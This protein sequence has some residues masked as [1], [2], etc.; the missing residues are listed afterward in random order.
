LPRTTD[1]YTTG[2]TFIAGRFL[3]CKGTWQGSCGFSDSVLEVFIDGNQPPGTQFTG[4]ALLYNCSR[5]CY[6][7]HLKFVMVM[8]EKRPQLKVS[9][10]SA[11]WSHRAWPYFAIFIFAL[12]I[13]LIYLSEIIDHPI[14]SILLGDAESYDVWA[15]E[16]VQKG[17]IGERTFYQ[18]PFYPY[19]LAFIYTIGAR[20]FIIVRLVQIVIGSASCVLLAAAGARFFGK[21]SGWIAG[22]LLSLYAPALFFD[23][24]IQ[25]AVLAM[26]FMC[27]LLFLMSRTTCLQNHKVRSGVWILIGATLACF[28]LVRENALILV[29]ATVIWLII[30]FWKSGWRQLLVKGMFLAVGL[31]IVFFPVTLRNYVVGG[32]FV[33]TTSQLGPNFYIGNSKEATGFYRPLIW[34]HS[35]WKFERIDAQNLAEKELGRVLTPNEVSD[36]WLAAAL[37][38]MREDPANW[39]RLMGR[40]W[41]MVWNS[42]EISDS[43]SIYA[44]YRFSNL[45]NAL[46]Q[47]FHFGVL[48]PLAIIGICLGWRDRRQLW[49]LAWVWFCF[50]A[51]VALFF[52]FARYRY[53]MIAPMILFAASGLTHLYQQVKKKHL[54]GLVGSVSLALLFATVVNWPMLSKAKMEAPTHFNIGY[55]LEKREELDAAQAFYLSSLAL[56]STSTLTYNNLGMVAMKQERPEEAITYFSKAVKAKPNNWDARVNLGI[57]LWGLGRKAEAVEQYKQVLKSEP[58]YNPSL[59]YNI[60]C[61]Y[62]LVGQTRQSMEWLK[63]AIDH[64]HNNWELIEKDPDLQ[65]LRE[66]PE[67]LELLK[68]SQ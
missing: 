66:L 14:I 65:N 44:H 33:L 60:A 23:L 26:F 7:Q 43:E 63:K 67:F 30:H 46:G 2:S 32:E 4:K 27:F 41:L 18:A 49:G 29:P 31:T 48:F 58:G 53:P 39:L 52:V 19:F 37:S 61:H 22:L 56:D 42:V 16:I 20:D 1:I 21:K 5:R 64:G 6:L 8:T 25:K 10:T 3:L 15:Q 36:Y 34:N 62:A 9:S 45:L 38:D 17:W 57:A 51:S 68:S 12:A 13:R 40:K 55:E 35:D 11:I 47:V 59:D 28:A 24:L 54:K 50:A